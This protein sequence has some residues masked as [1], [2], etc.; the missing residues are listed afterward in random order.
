MFS[1]FGGI[2]PDGGVFDFYQM[3]DQFSRDRLQKGTE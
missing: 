1:R 3:I 2:S